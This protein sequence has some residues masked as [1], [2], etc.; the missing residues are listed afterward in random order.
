MFSFKDL[1]LI[2]KLDLNDH[3]SRKIKMNIWFGLSLLWFRVLEQQLCRAEE[4]QRGVYLLKVAFK[5][6]QAK[7]SHLSQF[8]DGG[9]KFAFFYLISINN[10]T[11][12]EQNGHKSEQL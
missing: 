7:R 11:K 5:Q 3:R 6:Q 9:N 2:F 1:K 12:N 4:E 10:W 8:T